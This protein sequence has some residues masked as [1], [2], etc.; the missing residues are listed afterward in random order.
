MIVTIT[1]SL[2]D[3]P[4]NKSFPYFFGFILFDPSSHGKSF[5]IPFCGERK[6]ILSSG[7]VDSNM[8]FIIDGLEKVLGASKLVGHATAETISCPG[9]ACPS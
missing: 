3:S 7:I 2:L 8:F 6:I 4:N 1:P 5:I 9:G